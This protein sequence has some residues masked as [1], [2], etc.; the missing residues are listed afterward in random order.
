MHKSEKLVRFTYNGTGERDTNSIEL[1]E[2]FGMFGNI[3]D[4]GHV[5]VK[6]DGSNVG[7][8]DKGK[9]VPCG[10]WQAFLD[11]DKVCFRSQGNTFTSVKG[12]LNCVRIIAAYDLVGGYSLRELVYAMSDFKGVDNTCKNIAL[13]FF[14]LPC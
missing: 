10:D 5:T 3:T 14:G 9:I 6:P 13:E 12:H 11:G 1:A 2:R 7:Y 4:W 8:F